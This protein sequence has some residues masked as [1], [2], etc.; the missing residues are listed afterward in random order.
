MRRRSRRRRVT[1]M[2]N[3][4]VAVDFFSRPRMCRPLV[5]ASSSRLS[6]LS[7]AIVPVTKQ[8]YG[9]VY[10]YTV[11]RALLIARGTSN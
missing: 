9:P 8:N 11:R 2:I 4:F 10:T 7:A 5:T 3:E 1:S 6:V